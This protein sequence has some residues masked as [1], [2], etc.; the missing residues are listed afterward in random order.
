[1]TT[2]PQS[3][4]RTLLSGMGWNASGRWVGQLI[5]WSST[6]VVVR[7]LTPADY[8]LVAMGGTLFALMTLLGDGGIR[9]AIVSRSERE[10]RILHELTT[11]S[12]L[13]GVAGTVAAMALAYPLALFF[14]EPRLTPVVIVVGATYTILGFRMVPL[15]CLQRDLNYRSIAF[16][17]LLMVTASAITSVVIAWIGGG[18]WA[19]IWGNV[20]GTIAATCAAWYRSPQRLSRPVWHD[21]KAAVGFGNRLVLTDVAHWIRSNA[22]AVIIGRNIGQGALGTYRIAMEF[23]SLPLEKVAGAILQVTFPVFATIK[24]D[25]AALSRYLLLLTEALTFIIWPLAIGLILIADLAVAVVLGDQWSAV[26]LPLQLFSAASMVRTLS[27]LT[28]NITLV[29]G[30]ARLLLRVSTI[31]AMLSVAAMVA[32]APWGMPAIAGVWALSIPLLTAPILLVV[33]REIN[34][35]IGRFLRVMMPV[36]AGCTGEVVSVIALRTIG[37]TSTHPLAVQMLLC[38]TVGGVGYGLTTFFIARRRI[39]AVLASILRNVAPTPDPAS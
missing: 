28:H 10:P 17:D 14:R 23:A 31:G 33:L 13:L 37:W 35:P 8:G 24:H 26:V 25:K 6:L 30:N 32:A 38:I 1:M 4:D 20:A 9:T 22:D 7:L 27:P 39:S 19:L 3:L 2:P 11:V 29:L 12:V 16:N 18:Y 5:S 36:A 21:I 34:L 15:A